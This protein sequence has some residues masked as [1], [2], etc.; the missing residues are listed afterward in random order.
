MSLK[1]NAL[2]KVKSLIES[3]KFSKTQLRK[4]VADV[5]KEIFTNIKEKLID[6]NIEWNDDFPNAEEFARYCVASR[7]NASLM[8]DNI[9]DNLLMF[10]LISSF[11]G[12]TQLKWLETKEKRL[13]F[14][15]KMSPSTKEFL[16]LLVE[17]MERFSKVETSSKN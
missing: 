2:E 7:Q 12:K 15:M 13:E 16:E 3:E 17:K 9:A 10:Q 5:R 4:M 1:N 11:L 14:F 6:P 8:I